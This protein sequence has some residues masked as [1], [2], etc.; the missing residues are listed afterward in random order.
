MLTEF[1]LTPDAISHADGRVG[2]DV[3]R[4]IANCLFPVAAA[5]T[6]LFCKLG[7]DDWIRAVS[8]N[9]ARITNVN[10]RQ[11][12][13]T[14]FAKIVDQ[15]SVSCPAVARS[16]ND[17][18]SWIDAGLRSSAQ[19]PFGRI[20]VSGSSVPPSQVG[21]S[22]REFV[23]PEFWEELAN[24]RI[25][26]R[27]TATQENVLRAICTHSDWLVMRLP[28][29]R[30][31]N[32]DEIVTAKQIIRLANQVPA[33]FR[34]AEIDLHICLV[35]NITEERLI[36]GVAGELN[37]FSRQGAT[38]T[39]TVWPERHFVNRELLGGEYTTTSPGHRVRKPCWWITMTHVAVGSRNA[40]NAGEAGNTWGL[41]SRRLAHA[42]IDEIENDK[43]LSTQLLS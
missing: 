18:A 12:A 25:V 19:V 11:S 33:G 9:I 2:T 23:S 21:A 35:R 8:S 16:G 37:P 6:A 34:K 26:G 43:P 30:G 7:G 24:P 28:Q 36:R 10:H 4:E 39:L 27:E 3:V 20:V 31:G 29:I 14:L 13:M 1:L 40:A 32:D 17:E 15:L 22:L 41:F 42:R 38:I 5:P